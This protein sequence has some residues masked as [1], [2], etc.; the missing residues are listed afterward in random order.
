[1]CFLQLSIIY[2]Y[3]EWSIPNK[4][5]IRNISF[6]QKLYLNRLDMYDLFVLPYIERRYKMN[7]RNKVI[8]SLMIFVMTVQIFFSWSCAFSISDNS[9]EPA[10]INSA[11]LDSKS[12]SQGQSIENDKS[13]TSSTVYAT[14]TTGVP[15][16]TQIAIPTHIREEVLLD[17][18]LP[19]ST[20]PKDDGSGDSKVDA[21]KNKKRIIVKYKDVNNIESVKN[22]V[23]KEAKLTRLDLKRDLKSAKMQVYELNAAEFGKNILDKFKANKDVEYVQEDLQVSLYDVP[24]D[25]RFPEQWG[26]DNFG[27]TINGHAGVNGVDISALDAWDKTKGRTDVVVGVLDTGVDINHEDL[28]DNIYTNTGEI[29]NNGID[30]DNNGYIDDVNGWDFTDDNNTVFDSSVSDLHG[31]HVSGIIAAKDNDKG[32]RGV[33]PGIKIVPLKCINGNYGYTSDIIEAIEY[34]K[35]MGI[36]IVS[37]SW[38]GLEENEALYD[39]ME[40]SQILYVCAA[41]NMSSNTLQTPVYPACFNIPNIISVAAIQNNGNLASYS[42]YGNAIDVAAPGSDILSTTPGDSYGMMSGT[43]MAV[44]FIT[45]TAALIKSYDADLYINEIVQRIKNNVVKS[46]KL[47][48]KVNTEGWIDANAA[49]I[50]KASEPSV[51]P[52]ATPTP[53][54]TPTAPANVPTPIILSDDPNVD[55]DKGSLDN[56]LQK[57]GKTLKP[58]TAGENSPGS[59]EQKEYLPVDNGLD[60]IK[61][62]IEPQ[63]ILPLSYVDE[64]EPNN[65]S[66]IGMSIGSCSVFGS[67]ESSSDTDW[68]VINLD[69]NAQYR[70]KLAGIPEGNDFD[71]YV[72]NSNL[73]QVA[74]SRYGSNFDENITL[75]T[76]TAGLYYINVYVYTFNSTGDHSYQLMVYPNSSAPDSYEP[77]D[78]GTTAKAINSGTAINAT[79]NAATDD[80]WY[81]LDISRSGKITVTLNNIPAGC[82]YDILIFNRGSVTSIMKGS[83]NASNQSEKVSAVINWSGKYYIKVYSYSGYNASSSYELKA[84]VS[85]PDTYESNDYIG[86]I[87]NLN[88]GDSILATIDNQNDVDLYEFSISETDTYRFE[89]QN[90]PEGR[91]Y[92][93]YIYD[94]YGNLYAASLFGGNV[95]AI[96]NIDL[97]PG[98]YFM[99]VVSASG[100]SDVLRYSLSYCRNGE[101]TVY[102]PYISTNAGDIIEI[103]VSIKNVPAV[104][105]SSFNF[106]FTYNKDVLKYKGYTPGALTNN[107][108]LYI[109]AGEARD[110]VKVLYIDQSET[111][112]NPIVSSGEIIKLRFE[113]NENAVE[114][115]TVISYK[116][117]CFSR[118]I[119]GF[120]YIEGENDIILKPA[121]VSTG[122][123]GLSS[124]PADIIANNSD[125]ITAQNVISILGI[126]GDV[127]ADLDVDSD[128]YALMRQR[129]IGMITEFPRKGGINITNE[130]Y[131]A[132]VDGDGNFDSDDYAYIQ[133]YLIGMITTLPAEKLHGDMTVN[134]SYYLNYGK[135]DLDGHTLHIKGDL[136]LDTLH[137]DNVNIT[138]VKPYSNDKLKAILDINGG[139][140]IVEGTMRLHEKSFLYMNSPND[141]VLVNGDF[142]ANTQDNLSGCLTNGM[143]EIKGDFRQIA[144]SYDYVYEDQY[145]ERWLYNPGNPC[146]FITGRNNATSTDFKVKMSGKGTQTIY[147]DKTIPGNYED[148]RQIHDGMQSFFF[149]L[150]ITKP[151]ESYKLSINEANF[152]ANHDKAWVYL[153]EEFEDPS[154]FEDEEIADMAI[155]KSGLGVATVNAKIYTFGGVNNNSV[156][157]AI[158]EYD[159]IKG[160]WTSQYNRSLSM[161]RK[162]MAVVAAN[163]NN[164]YII[165][166][167]NNSQYVNTV[168][169]FSSSGQ[170]NV[171]PETSNLPRPMIGASAVVHG[172]R[173]YVMGGYNLTDGYSN[174]MQ[175]FDINSQTWV[176]QDENNRPYKN[177]LNPRAFASAVLYDG[178][179]YVMGGR[180]DVNPNNHYLKTMD[181]YDISTGQWSA[182]PSMIGKRAKFCANVLNDRIYVLGG[183][184]GTSYLSSIEIFDIVEDKWIEANEFKRLPFIEATKEV[185][186]KTVVYNES[187]AAFGTALVYSQIYLIGGENEDGYLTRNNK[188][189]PI[190]LPGSRA[191]NGT[192]SGPDMKYANGGRFISGNYTAEVSDIKIES[193]GL[194]IELVRT[195][196]SS[197]NYEKSMLGN[198]W[199]L[200]YDAYITEKVEYC[201]VTG[202]DVNLREAPGKSTKVL[203]TADRGCIVFKDPDNYDENIE[204]ISWRKIFYIDKGE[205]KPAYIAKNYIQDIKSGVE[206]KMGAGPSTYFDSV[207]NKY[208]S[209]Y[210]CYD[211]LSL[212]STGEFILKKNDMTSYGFIQLLDDSDKPIEKDTY[213]LVWIKDKF[214]NV[215]EITG[216]IEE[217]RYRID[218]VEEKF[219]AEPTK[220]RSLEFIYSLNK[221]TVKD[222]LQRT[223][224]YNLDPATGNLLSVENIFGKITEYDY[225]T[226]SEDDSQGK[227]LNKL[228]KISIYVKD[229][230]GDEILKPILTNY[231]NKITARRYKETDADGK[232][233]YWICRDAYGDESSTTGVPYGTVERQYYDEN[234]NRTIV[235]Y[236]NYLKIPKEEIYP[237]GS[238]VE[239]EYYY[240]FEN[241]NYWT[242]TENINISNSNK[243]NNIAKIREYVTDK[244]GYTTMEEKDSH[245]NTVVLTDKFVYSKSSNNYTAGQLCNRYE[246]EYVESEDKIINNLT[247]SYKEIDGVVQKNGRVTYKYN[248][249]NKAKLEKVE[250]IS[251]DTIEEKENPYSTDW[252]KITSSDYSGG[253]AIRSN[254]LNSK[255]TFNFTGNEIKWIGYSNSSTGKAKVTVCD[256]SKD[257]GV[258]VI[259]NQ[260]SIIVDTYSA[261]YSPN[262]LLFNKIF[263]KGG[264]HKITIEVNESKY[265]G[266]DAFEIITYAN[267]LYSYPETEYKI[268]GLVSLVTDPDSNVTSYEYETDTCYL[269]KV[270][271][272]EG[273]ETSYTYD[274]VGRITSETS[275]MG[276]VTRYAYSNSD[277]NNLNKSSENISK[278]VIVD[279]N[280]NINTELKNEYK[281]K[282]IKT[283]YDGYGN[284]IQE[285]APNQ[286]VKSGNDSDKGIKY[287]YYNTGRLKTATIILTDELGAK[288]KEYITEYIYDNAGNKK[289]EK[290]YEK[291]LGD[292][293]LKDC[294]E[295]IYEYDNMDRLYRV[296]LKTEDMSF[297]VVLEE[298]DYETKVNLSNSLLLDDVKIHKVF[299]DA[300][301]N[302]QKCIITKVVNDYN[303]KT[304]TT[305]ETGKASVKK[306]YNKIGDL[307]SQQIGDDTRNTTTFAYD[308]FG[309]VIRKREPIEMKGSNLLTSIK[310]YKYTSAGNLIEESVGVEK[311][312]KYDDQTKNVDP[313][314]YL[315]KSYTYNGN[316]KITQIFIPEGKIKD[317]R[318]DN[319]GNLKQEI[320]Y[321]SS[322]KSSKVVYRNNHFGKPEYKFEF[323]DVN[324]IEGAPSSAVSYAIVTKYDYDASGNV[325]KV[326]IKGAEVSESNIQSYSDDSLN[327]DVE[328]TYDDLNRLKSVIRKGN[329]LNENVLR[330]SGIY[331]QMS[332]N[333]ITSTEYNW[334]GKPVQITDGNQ[335]V[336]NYKYF[337]NNSGRVEVVSKEITSGDPVEE[338][339]QATFYDW[340]GRLKAEV[341]PKNYKAAG[342]GEDSGISYI[343]MN[344]IRYEYSYPDN[345]SLMVEKLYYGSLVQYD[346]DNISQ[347]P[348]D[349]NSSKEEGK[350]LKRTEYDLFGNISKEWDATGSDQSMTEY[351][352]NFANQLIGFRDPQTRKYNN[353][354]SN[355][356]FS[357]KYSYDTLGRKISETKLKGFDG[358]ADTSV[359]FNNGDSEEI[360]FVNTAYSYDYNGN[361]LKMW[362]KKGDSDAVDASNGGTLMLDDSY[363]FA[364][365]LTMH[366]YAVAYNSANPSYEPLTNTT[367]Y[368]YNA[369]QK[370]KAVHKEIDANMKY[371]SGDTFDPEIITYDTSYKYDVMGNVVR[372]F[373][374]MHKLNLY[375]YDK[376]GRLL[377][378]NKK[379]DNDANEKCIVTK[380][381][382]DRNG[383]K[384]AEVDGN[385]NIKEYVYDKLNRLIETK[386]TVGDNLD[387]EDLDPENNDGMLSYHC[388]V[389]EYNDESS[390]I[391]QTDKVVRGTQEASSVKKFEYDELNRLIKKADNN[392]DV[393]KIIYNSNNLQEYSFDANNHYTKYEY[394]DNGR[395]TRTIRQHSENNVHIQ[396]QSYDFAGNIRA[397]TDGEGNITNY[398][399]NEYDRLWYVISPKNKDDSSAVRQKTRYSYDLAGN[400]LQVDILNTNSATTETVFQGTSYAYTIAGQI[401]R[402]TDN[403]GIYEEY[404]Y[405]PDG[406]LRTKTFKNMACTVYDYDI[407]G[408]LENERT[409]KSGATDFIEISYEYDVV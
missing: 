149:K 273:G 219:D 182:K 328:Y 49:I 44:P 231:Y 235:K 329:I 101:F 100:Y 381:F 286:Y 86:E 78:S 209:P 118:R 399:Y 162:D 1:M 253:T 313:T 172:N 346:P 122:G 79:I 225:V 277:I 105:I 278:I 379:S 331:T 204:G 344:H 332:A 131:S 400:M 132:D 31:T 61:D 95:D 109:E 14:E 130:L 87:T 269:S 366:K 62:G 407:H 140:L 102:L 215:I 377:S 276:F 2:N 26:L 160:E 180:N 43:S 58:L 252:T 23:K 267:T 111:F 166:G 103:P 142:I 322:S 376:S 360:Y 280:A 292:S 129:L 60:G 199:R 104:G 137:Y 74:S 125:K 233:R 353:D 136:V 220:N 59:S 91:D 266:I 200:N 243:L 213:R 256:I 185:D 80:D 50:D 355:N 398:I 387:Q 370:V 367:S 249:A 55:I 179:I 3:I 393:E 258:E 145:G 224:S 161:P 282:A 259:S 133:Q 272:P 402:K 56:S 212:S 72:F 241:D 265:V 4:M 36:E 222:K 324:D 171:L 289:T 216:K 358:V 371:G 403:W 73:E 82:D 108:N 263:S 315:T 291:S 68:Y 223:V 270:R 51:T 390:V 196:D 335:N 229:E 28:K 228:E 351:C 6:Y 236:E 170:V 97:D 16:A 205:K 201:R 310:K 248:T 93:L 143:L 32:I 7:T 154:V 126:R 157:S 94:I 251:I 264:E 165:G 362:L 307:V 230:N 339:K 305:I 177:M 343:N 337:Y 173:I 40:N 38:G 153:E 159:P 294:Q 227:N 404:K 406:S 405:D 268:K 281:D 35:I 85:T 25:T 146:N 183:F 88:M 151:L 53:T 348:E 54:S 116:D 262:Q 255:Y 120:P 202:S 156:S 318:Y 239:H 392:T 193:T 114:A 65:T 211:K 169:V 9:S 382:Y 279:N 350:L 194:P 309:R 92:N 325:T 284:K 175:V 19:D 139:K 391:S 5:P 372:K 189:Y 308:G 178:K 319:D 250:R 283:V 69:A 369:L 389:Y 76:T 386:I 119:S 345:A 11:N 303:N 152:Y 75:H 141:Y 320:T 285:I 314:N 247:S 22:S 39:A 397:K 123:Y 327:P 186:G 147:F 326:K 34:C 17:D 349:C 316:G 394:D 188:F 45:G 333:I 107:A 226:S 207:D 176:T 47:V 164:I 342:N 245:G 83:Y 8:S 90:I 334:E 12:L 359:K 98:E 198:G 206:L 48:G 297:P 192:A 408:N 347:E 42:N 89:L 52:V 384:R 112:S 363:D 190:V 354:T 287:T 368:D 115:A 57:N 365:N 155:P 217:G 317:Y 238:K 298:Y 150:V 195:Y 375:V 274:V 330:I 323:I 232:V 301:A 167:E 218:K 13:N 20:R 148:K 401:L 385:G 21:E 254:I 214:G 374:N 300:D 138:G 356:Y 30:D 340:A 64:I 15:V 99:K 67:I 144:G 321:N 380:A 63:N 124:I 361:L 338:Q 240:K 37:C 383:N 396:S 306:S 288:V 33:A 197:D 293:E 46:S 158:N 312:I 27:Q 295:K 388:T 271:N 66:S 357:V 203:A 409:T 187:R 168:E 311:V 299:Y 395:L 134:G 341:S 10:K 352:Y 110:G 70:I 106:T 234:N 84:V 210:G 373:D 24:G 296:S 242:D 275:P 304:E 117:Y 184:D 336:T 246:Y 244:Y 18:V 77:N 29:P 261:T 121:I 257:S 135:L 290:K 163:N 302:P 81:V 41:G 237:D 128:D 260:E 208:I 364:G 181:V 221:I 96:I 174:L 378:E 113:V 127:D 191:Y 71:L